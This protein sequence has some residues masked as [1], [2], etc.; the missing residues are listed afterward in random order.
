MA[1]KGLLGALKGQALKMLEDALKQMQERQEGMQHKEDVPQVKWQKPKAVETGNYGSKPD[2]FSNV[3][4]RNYQ[5]NRHVRLQSKEEGGHYIL[6]YRFKD[7]KE[8][9]QEFSIIYKLATMR[10][11][12][13]RFGVPRQFLG[14]FRMTAAQMRRWKQERDNAVAEGLFML[15]GNMLKPDPDRIV[16]YYSSEFCEQIANQIVDSLERYGTDTPRERIEMAMKFIQDIPYGIPE[17]ND[18]NYL[19]A[20][21]ITPPQI[22]Y[23]KFG[24]CDSKSF[25]FAGI[26]S[27]LI[28]PDKIAFLTMPGHLLT[29]IKFKQERGMTSVT[30]GREKFVLAETAGP[31][32]NNFGVPQSYNQSGKLELHKL[33]FNGPKKIIPL[34]KTN[35]SKSKWY[36][37]YVATRTKTDRGVLEALKKIKRANAPVKSI[38]F[39]DNGG[40]AVIAGKSRFYSYGIPNAMASTLDQLKDQNIEIRDVA[41]NNKDEFVISYHNG[42]GFTGALSQKDSESLGATLSEISEKHGQPIYDIVFSKHATPGWIVVFGQYGNGVTYQLPTAMLRKFKPALDDAAKEGINSIAFTQN[43]GWVIVSGKNT[44]RMHLNSVLAKKLSDQLNDLKRAGAVINK[45]YFTPTDDWVIIYND[46][47]FI[48]SM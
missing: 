46:S 38:V 47:N 45:I 44:C 7:H 41:L 29:A 3:S 8:K 48:S 24:D 14:S 5:K 6:S 26:L 1:G 34:R 42:F 4:S 28:D 19:Y 12:I 21:V 37:P 30:Y 23:L 33:N 43:I 20:G 22:M 16:S 39:T 13:S 18:P 11:M 2:P 35:A 17:Q 32:R 36:N 27:F 31:G 25:M 9:F 15:E 10:K 40:Y